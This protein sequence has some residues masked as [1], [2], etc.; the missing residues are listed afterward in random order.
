MPYAW[1]T[2]AID[3]VLNFWTFFAEPEDYY[4]IACC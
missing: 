4:E 1:V 3:W 2:H